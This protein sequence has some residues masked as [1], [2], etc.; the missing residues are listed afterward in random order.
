MS[1]QETIPDRVKRVIADQLGIPVAEVHPE[2]SLDDL[3]ADSLDNV[4]IVMGLEEEFE[5]EIPQEQGEALDTVQ[6]AI[7]YAIAHVRN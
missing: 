4:E 5:L 6:Q 2:M 1:P 7:D 3:G